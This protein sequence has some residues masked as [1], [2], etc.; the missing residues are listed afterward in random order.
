MTSPPSGVSCQAVSE[1]STYSALVLAGGRGQRLGGV[2]KGWITW[3][4]KPLIEHALSRLRR[5]TLL[6]SQIIISANR[7][8]PDYQATGLVVVRDIRPG[9]AG[10]L[11]GIEAAL[12]VT[13]SDYLLV[14]PC[15]L[16]YF[17]ET[18]A[19]ALFDS[20]FEQGIIRPAVASVS[21]HWQPLCLMLPTTLGPSLTDFLESGQAKVRC[22]LEQV[23]ARVVTFE[24][25]HEFMNINTIEQLD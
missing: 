17:P 10:P 25:M 12:A 23:H 24:A 2:D 3:R 15:D 14:V 19:Q 4:G 6:P 11:A 21:G 20:V 8:L 22:W 7:R 9:F 16:P 1:A 5:Q 18:L 13:E